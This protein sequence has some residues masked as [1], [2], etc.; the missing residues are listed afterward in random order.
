MSH[1][2]LSICHLAVLGILSASCAADVAMPSDCEQCDAQ[3]EEGLLLATCEKASDVNYG[4][5]RLDDSLAREGLEIA[6]EVA[7]GGTNHSPS[8]PVVFQELTFDNE[9]FR[10]GESEIVPEDERQLI[11]TVRISN[12]ELG[13][14]SPLRFEPIVSEVQIDVASLGKGTEIRAPFSLLSTSVTSVNA[15]EYAYPY[16]HLSIAI[17][18]QEQSAMNLLVPYGESVAVHVPHFTGQDAPTISNFSG[19]DVL[20]ITGL[21]KFEV[22]FANGTSTIW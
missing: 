17:P 11:F 18:T 2:N 9:Q 21:E 4:S 6:V 15:G 12:S 7:F 13:Q 19:S 16:S 3:A 5:C 20:P 1:P 10:Y 14:W 22:E 8:E